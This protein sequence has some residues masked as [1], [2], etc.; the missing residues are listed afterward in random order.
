MSVDRDLRHHLQVLR[1]RWWLIAL[2]LIAS[3]SL[4]YFAYQQ[5]VPV[6]RA[7]AKLTVGLERIGSPD[8]RS[9]VQ[10]LSSAR[11]LLVTYAE[12]IT[13][14]PVAEAAIKRGRL[15]LTSSQVLQGL[16]ASRVGDTQ[17][18]SIVYRARDPILAART[19]NAV[20]VAFKEQVEDTSEGRQPPTQ[21]EIIEGAIAP[22]NPVNLKREQNLI[23]AIVLGL[24]M[25]IALAYL[26]E[27]LDV[28]VKTRED[29]EGLTLPLIGS[30]PALQSRNGQVYLEMDAQGPAGEAFRKL[31]TAIGFTALERPVQ[32]LLV[33]SP[34]PGEG[35]STVALNLAVAYA[36]T[37][38]N[39]ILVEADLRRP[40]IH[41]LFGVKDTHGLTTAAIGQISIEEA[42]RKTSMPSLSIIVAGAIPPNPVELLDSA[43]MTHIIE[44]LRSM[45]DMVILDAPPLVPVAD[46]AALAGR[47]DGV[48]LVAKAGE[49]HR[50]RLSECAELVTRAGGRL[51]GVVLNRQRHEDAGYEYGYY[52]SYRSAARSKR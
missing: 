27:S 15:S 13:T 51:L 33:S 24:G 36:H 43:S 39:T 41:G 20:A 10:S 49:T 38:L 47:S 45:F 9:P 8:V 4:G 7:E 32:V 5:I 29:V 21:I 6:Y 3:V 30:V 37:G 19:A 1:K 52:Y 40:V 42:I 22:S 16:E 25:G 2:S 26:L 12:M 46:P 48:L 23:L 28:T 31:R 11:E 34:H 44:T 14:R 17:L 35:K 50:K 18:L